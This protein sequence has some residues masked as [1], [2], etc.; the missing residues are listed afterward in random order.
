MDAL[1]AVLLNHDLKENKRKFKFIFQKKMLLYSKI[2]R[3][4]ILLKWLGKFLYLLRNSV[5]RVNK[6]LSEKMESHDMSL[7]Y[8][9]N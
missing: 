6:I 1:F 5:I 3:G 7:K 9:M 8:N 4:Y 2:T